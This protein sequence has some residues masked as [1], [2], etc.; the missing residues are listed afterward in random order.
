MR[1][2]YFYNTLRKK[3]QNSNEKSAYIISCIVFFI[4]ILLII[5]DVIRWKNGVLA[6][7]LGLSIAVVTHLFMFS[8]L[9]PILNDKYQFLRLKPVATFKTNALLV[10]IIM[11]LTILPFAFI[12]F[13]V[14]GKLIIFTI[15]VIIINLFFETNIKSKLIFN[16]CLALVILLIPILMKKELSLIYINILEIFSIVGFI[17]VFTK[18]RHQNRINSHEIEILLHKNNLLL[19]KQNDVIEEKNSELQSFAYVASHDLKEPLRMISSY[20]GLI[21]RRLN[22]H[23]TQDTKEFMGFVIDGISNMNEMLDD[24]LDY[25]T[26]DNNQLQLEFLNLNDIILKVSHNLTTIINETD[27]QINIENELPLIKVNKTYASLLFQN[28]ISNAIKFR[29]KDVQPNITIDCSKDKGNLI[30]SIED[31]GIGIPKGSLSSIFSIFN[32]L[33]NKNEFKGHGIG[34]ATCKKIVEKLNGE[35][36]VESQLGKGSRFFI[37]LPS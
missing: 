3:L 4:S 34:L 11:H 24:L 8:F 7:S 15:F 37:R 30:I 33:H 16:F 18:Y 29:K 27:A 17:F 26:L 2:A 28:L 19:Q 14:L 32:R 6:E 22:K 12:S 23:L 10:I 36:W 13:Y 20:T 9:I 21:E 35:I 25:A 5:L 1:D 31:N